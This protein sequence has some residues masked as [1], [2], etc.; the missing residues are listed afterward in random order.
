[1]TTDEKAGIEW[2]NSLTEADRRFWILLSLGN[3][4]AD[5]WAYYKR[6]NGK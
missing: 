4:P 2:W 3:R 1:M 5:A 6:S